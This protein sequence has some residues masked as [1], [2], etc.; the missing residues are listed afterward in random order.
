MEKPNQIKESYADGVLNLH[1]C[2]GQVRID[3]M[4]FQPGTDDGKGN[5]AKRV[6]ERLIMSPQG[7][8]T[9]FDSSRQLIERL[10]QQGI[11]ARN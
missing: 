6:S 3:L 10:E 9:L 4:T 8:I 11:I 1:F 5:L 2:G 7:F